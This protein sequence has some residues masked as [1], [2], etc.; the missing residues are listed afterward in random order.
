MT[1]L[2]IAKLYLFLDLT[3]KNLLLDLKYIYEG[4]FRIKD[5]Y[6]IFNEQLLTGARTEMRKLKR[7]MYK[8]N[9]QV[10]LLRQQGKFTTYKFIT[11]R[12]IKEITYMN[13]VMKKHVKYVIE[14]IATGSAFK[15]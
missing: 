3:I 4:P 7:E 5:P 10:V 14:R 13:A 2:E 6:I 11:K 1:D 12:E 9:I 15:I 8:R